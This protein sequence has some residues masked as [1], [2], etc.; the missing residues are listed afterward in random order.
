MVV[1]RNGKQ[2]KTGAADP[3]YCDFPL[4]SLPSGCHQKTFCSNSREQFQAIHIPLGVFF[5]SWRISGL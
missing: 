1:G 5:T 4:G 3:F 2:P